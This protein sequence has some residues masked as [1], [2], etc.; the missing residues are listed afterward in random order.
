MTLRAATELVITAAPSDDVR[1]VAA[2]MRDRRVGSVVI[3]EGNRPVGIVTD[4]DLAV[5]VVAAGLPAETPVADVM[6]IDP[7]VARSDAGVD[8]ILS[9]MRKAGARR[10]PLVDERGHLVGI[11]THD[12]LLLL[13]AREMT[14]LGEGI[15][16]GVDAS[17]LR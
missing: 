14:D 2:R 9:T 12:D 10:L 16:Q 4:R 6:T 15:E 17:E 11:I 5:R 3:V 1:A 8:T 7:T 13:L